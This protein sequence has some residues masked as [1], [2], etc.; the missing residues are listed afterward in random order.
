MAVTRRDVVEALEQ[1]ARECFAGADDQAAS[2]DDLN[3]LAQRLEGTIDRYRDRV[4]PEL[5]DVDVGPIK[6]PTT[7]DGE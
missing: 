3:E 5:E 7:G 6:R 4:H 1:T 2:V